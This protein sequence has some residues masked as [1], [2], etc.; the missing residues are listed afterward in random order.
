MKNDKGCCE[1]CIHLK[2]LYFDNYGDEYHC[3]KLIFLISRFPDKCECKELLEKAEHTNETIS[4][5]KDS[6]S[7]EQQQKFTEIMNFWS[8]FNGEWKVI[9]FPIETVPRHILDK[10]KEFKKYIRLN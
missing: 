4:F 9:T 7:Q 1:N 3:Q 2:T 8:N 10:A 6:F 5:T